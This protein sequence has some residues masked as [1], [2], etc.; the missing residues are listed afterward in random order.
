MVPEV[1]TYVCPFCGCEVRV[2]KPCRG[3]AK[4]VRKPKPRKPP[5]HQDPSQDGLNLPDDD[6][7]YDAFVTREFG[8]AP[9]QVLDIKWYW[10]LLAVFLLVAMGWGA[11]MIG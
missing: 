6:F 1:M 5:W 2:G 4:K 7:D 3:C 10:W 8:K 9:H 11:L